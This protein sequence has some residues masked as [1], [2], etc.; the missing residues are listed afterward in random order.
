[1]PQVAARP[2]DAFEPAKGPVDR[3]AAVAMVKLQKVSGPI[4]AD[5]LRRAIVDGIQDKDGHGASS[6]LSTIQAWGTAHAG[7][8]TKAAK[9]VLAAC[10]KVW[11]AA[12]KDGQTGLSAAQVTK[13]GAAMAPSSSSSATWPGTGATLPKFALAPDSRRW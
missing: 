4:S 9:E 6:E 12:R 1:M 7:R 10:V 3:S 13:L 2:V 5:A 11:T 8:L